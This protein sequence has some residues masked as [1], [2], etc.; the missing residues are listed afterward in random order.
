MV[1]EDQ[2]RFQM[3]GRQQLVHATLAGKSQEMAEQYECALRVLRENAN[4]GRLFLAA[5]SIREMTGALPKMLDLPVF[6]DLGRLGD[7][8]QELEAAWEGTLRSSCHKNGRWAG[9]ID[10]PLQ[11]FLE[12]LQDFFQWCRDNRPKR[13]GI[14]TDLFRRAD[15][16]GLVL[17]ETLERPRTERWL[18]L[19]SY[20]VKTAHRA[21]TTDEELQAHI[22]ELE[23]FLLE[24]L[25]RQP[26]EDFSAI[27]AILHEETPDD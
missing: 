7:K 22:A 18:E 15:P 2:Q 12:R 4:P 21:Q 20:F 9:G 13:R 19:H 11:H 6:A 24:M 10:G 27:D 26:S 17:P 14:V 3:T 1:P 25:S 16:A 23:Q 5:H 8:V